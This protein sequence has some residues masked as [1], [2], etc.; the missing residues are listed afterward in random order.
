MQKFS[1]CFLASAFSF[2][3]VSGGAQPPQHPPQRV[4]GEANP[5]L[6][7]DDAVHSLLFRLLDHLGEDRAR[8][9]IWQKRLGD[10]DLVLG[11]VR[12]FEATVSGLDARAGRLKDENW[13][14]PDEHTMGILAD[15]QREKRVAVRRLSS[16]LPQEFRAYAQQLKAR[17]TMNRS[18]DKPPT[19]WERERN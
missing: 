11:L 2:L 14:D 4:N 13:P 5:E 12:E 9:Y 3:L 8:M 10:P 17:T 6:I 18:P 1:L 15:L 16:R 19:Q 7:P